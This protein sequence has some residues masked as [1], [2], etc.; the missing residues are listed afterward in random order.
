MQCVQVLVEVEC[1]GKC[2]ESP[3]IYSIEEP[4]ILDIVQLVRRGMSSLNGNE[5]PGADRG[6]VV[7][8]QSVQPDCGAME[9][10][11]A[12]N[13]VVPAK[14]KSQCCCIEVLVL[15]QLWEA[16]SAEQSANQ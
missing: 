2:R 3:I 5:L 16:N 11:E 9:F 14:L 13:P 10:V 7:Q 4:N 12:L 6:S 15:E 1:V 8:R